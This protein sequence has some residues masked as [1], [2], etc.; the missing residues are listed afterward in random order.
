[1]AFPVIP[2]IG[3]KLVSMFLNKKRI[4]GW[5][6]AV[7]LAVGAAV[8]GMQTPEFKEAVCSAPIIEQTAEVNQ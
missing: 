8:A 1:M 5:I 4:I 2:L 7:G 3:A 6:S